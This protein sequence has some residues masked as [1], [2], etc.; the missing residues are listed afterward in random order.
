MRCRHAVLLCLSALV[1]ASGFALPSDQITRVA[2]AKPGAGTGGVDLAS[3]QTGKLY[4]PPATESFT[5]DDDG[6]LTSD[7]RWTYTWD[8]ENRLTAMQENTATLPAGWVRQRLEFSYDA[9][10]R[11]TRKTVKQWDGAAWQTTSDMGYVY[12]G[13]N[14][15]AE[16]S[17][18]G[19]SP[20][21]VRIYVWGLDV[22][23]SLQGAGG[24]G[25][26]LWALTPNSSPLTHY[27]C[28][29][30]NGNIIGWVDASTS[31][32]VLKLD[33][34]PFGGVVMAANMGTDAA[35][36]AAARAIPFRFSTKYTDKE[37]GLSY[38]GL[39]FYSSNLGRWPNP[40]P[41]GEIGGVNLY[42][43]LG[44]DGV[45]GVDVLGLRDSPFAKFDPQSPKFDKGDSFNN[46]PNNVY[47][48]DKCGRRWVWIARTKQWLRLSDE[49]ANCD[50][51]PADWLIDGKEN[52]GTS[53]SQYATGSLGDPKNSMKA[54]LYGPDGML[55][56]SES[57]AAKA[58]LMNDPAVQQ[59]M[60]ADAA[61]T[62]RNETGKVFLEA[63][64]FIALDGATKT[65]TAPFK[66][67]EIITR[68]FA[69]SGGRVEMAAEAIING[70][71]LHLK[72]I[73]VFPRGAESLDI[74]MRE[75]LRLRGQLADEVAGMGFDS[76]RITG[77]RL[78]GA[79][80][81][82]VVDMTIDLT[83]PR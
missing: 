65:T 61:R 1:C 42:G 16:L 22:S 9:G 33:Y 72:D 38:Y 43:M 81:G 24:V 52:K 19:S 82:K 51:C 63:G 41:L 6:N 60:L 40:D 71:S 76:L 39:R 55:D 32:P 27:P 74:G 10:S 80:P 54:V 73:A 48:N 18:T 20:Q 83:K 45:N 57:A 35:S 23:G 68:E 46:D 28:Y 47:K 44:N 36:S 13:W 37:T 50:S 29:D 15:I 34:D 25:G 75:V 77:K 64:L 78:T 53:Q 2:A 31:S 67:G 7:S 26:L 49:Q 3:L 17:L 30:G 62:V 4:L 12:D 66:S 14:L 8:A 11:R 56:N 58:I 59:A 21:L 69:S 79:N 5:Y 70:R